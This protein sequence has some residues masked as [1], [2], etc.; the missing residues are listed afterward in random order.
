MLSDLGDL[1]AAHA[2]GDDTSEQFRDFMD[3][4]GDFFPEG[5]QDMDELLDSLAQRAAECGK[6]TCTGRFN[7]VARSS[8]IRSSLFSTR[9][10][11]PPTGIG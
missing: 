7:S 10:A 3:K 6:V 8:A 1:L 5:P 4:H 11:A 9:P 2:R